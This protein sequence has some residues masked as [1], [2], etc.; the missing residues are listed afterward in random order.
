[1]NEKVNELTVD[2]L[3]NLISNV[4]QEKLDDMLEDVKLMLD[5][6]YVNSIKEA[7]EEYKQG[8]VTSIDDILST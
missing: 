5:S 3:R 7:R 8:K 2:E 6:E 4:V 1:M